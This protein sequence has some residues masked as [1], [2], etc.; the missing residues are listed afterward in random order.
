APVSAGI[1]SIARLGFRNATFRPGRSTLCIAMIATATFLLV[2]LDA[3]RQT[4]AAATAAGF[5]LLAEAALPLI[6]NPHTAAG[7]EP[8]YTPPKPRRA[9]NPSTY[10]AK[11]QCG[12]SRSD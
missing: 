8:L 7:H 12:G 9:A 6:H 1:H 10:P 4:G 3:F 5:P 2:A 11:P